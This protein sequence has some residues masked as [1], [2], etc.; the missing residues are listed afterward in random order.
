MSAADEGGEPMLR[1][2]L[3]VIVDAYAAFGWKLPLLGALTAANALLEGLTLAMLL[4]LLQ[5]V[6]MEAQESRIAQATG[7]LFASIGVAV[8]PALI[9]EVLGVLLIASLA[10]FLVQAYLATQLQSQYVA[11]WQ[12]RV[13]NAVISANWA[14][15]RLQS[16][17]ELVGALST[18]ASRIGGAFYQANLIASSVIFLIVQIAIAAFIAPA[19]TALLLLLAAVLFFV[20]EHMVR[21]AVHI[22]GELTN[23]NSA[24]FATVGEIAGSMK[25]IKATA[26]EDS[27][28]AWLGRHFAVIRDLTFRN[29]FDVQLVR[30]IFE[31][32]STGGVVLLLLLGP[33]LFKIDVT[34]ILIVIA[35]FVRLFPKVTGLRQ[36]LQ[37]I[38]LLLPAFDALRG[39]LRSAER[40][41]E[42]GDGGAAIRF[43]EPAAI[44]LRNV[45]LSGDA[46]EPIL[47]DICLKIAPGEH[48][49]FVG[50]TGAG[51]TTLLD[52]VLGLA[53]P[54]AGEVLVDGR[55]LSEIDLAGWR[56]VV[57]YL[58]QEPVMLAR[59]VRDNIAWNREDASAREI[60][61]ALK[62]ADAAFV[63]AMPGG[64]EAVVGERGGSLSGG[65]RQRLALAR[66]LL[67][68]PRLLVLDEATSAL[69]VETEQRIAASIRKRRGAITVMSITHR[70]SSARYADQIVL[71]DRGEVVERGGFAEL[72][73]A[74]RRFAAM[75]RAQ[76]GHQE[77]TALADSEP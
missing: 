42:R 13:F 63:F 29:A 22:G 50:P 40:A 14:F 33:L 72:M 41:C 31:Y 35:I 4:P 8:T 51:K 18:E 21:R 44:E 54:A 65:E 34:A 30:A 36:C 3:A 26:R 23:A 61:E 62:A 75:W 19:V 5:I 71:L 6:G 25:T 60:E 45:W 37:S 1:S 49:A 11:I 55:K 16:S 7:A 58:G 69:D 64:I 2:G 66:A 68:A 67:G 74:Q 27:A 43:G 70:L 53:T 48:V 76:E 57:G 59:S 17:G 9:G 38:G 28:K 20:T 39:L 10:V 24:M 56:H 32:A 73:A 15:L 12:E 52:C 46:G 77:A 47:R